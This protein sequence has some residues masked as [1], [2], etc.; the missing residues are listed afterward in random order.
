MTEE[1]EETLKR[2]FERQDT[3]EPAKALWPVVQD[4]VLLVRGIG[5]KELEELPKIARSLQGIE[6][7]LKR[8]ANEHTCTHEPL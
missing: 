1:Q 8:I 7:Q 3:K 2:F 6:R 5:P 4:F